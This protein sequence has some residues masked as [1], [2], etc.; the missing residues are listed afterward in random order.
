MK[1]T[2]Q[3]PSI[4]KEP[5]DMSPK[6]KDISEFEKKVSVSTQIEEGKPIEKDK[7]FNELK[8]IANKIFKEKIS[9]VSQATVSEVVDVFLRNKFHPDFHNAEFFKEMKSTIVNFMCYDPVLTKRLEITLA[10]LAKG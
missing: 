1:I 10:Q 3:T 2:R 4:H 8:T 5:I 7:I 9:S 6:K